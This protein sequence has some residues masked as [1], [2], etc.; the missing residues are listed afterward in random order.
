MS[1]TIE[2]LSWGSIG[3]SEHPLLAPAYSFENLVYTSGSIGANEDGTFPPTA[4]AQAENAIKGLQKVLQAAGSDLDMVLKV[5]LFVNKSEDA[6]AVNA[7]YKKY[8]PSMPGRS[9]I[10]VGFPNPEILV[11]LECVAVKKSKAKL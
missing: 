3:K 6:A 1:N 9:C 8:F 2:K 10:L 11:E 4:A 7:V 5:L